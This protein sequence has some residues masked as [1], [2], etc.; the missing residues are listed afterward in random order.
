MPLVCNYYLTLRCN[1]QC[2]F[3]DI[4]T[5]SDGRLAKT[6]EVL[7]NLSQLPEVGVRIVDFTGGEP[8]LHPDLPAFLQRARDLKLRTTVTTNALL[9]PKRARELAGRVNLLHLSIDAAQPELHDRL[10]GVRCFD[11]VMESLEL[12]LSLGEKPELLFTATKAN[13]R[14]LDALARLAGEFGVILIVNPLFSIGAGEE[15]LQHDELRE[16]MASCRRPYVYLNGGVARLMLDGGNDPQKPRCRAVS[17]TA[18]IS[19]NNELLLPCYHYSREAL[20]I[21]HDLREAIFHPRRKDWLQRQGREDFCQGCAINCYL[22][23]SLLYR[24]DRYL[25]AFAPWVAKYFYYKSLGPRRPAR[26]API[27]PAA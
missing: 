19:P 9:Y 24:A 20:P 2:S 25:A 12:A 3:C 26:R 7:N 11:K 10:R 15:A 27:R 4:W 14:E 21:G 5:R 23:P 6:Q 17:A 16:L 1:A 18:V 22:A 8:L 13:Y